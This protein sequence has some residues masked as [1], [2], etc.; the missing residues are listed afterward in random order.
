MTKYS[1][2]LRLEIATAVSD[3]V[4]TAAG[5]AAKYG[6]RKSNVERWVAL[7][8]A[9]GI[10][11]IARERRRY[12][13]E[14]KQAVV[15]DMRK[16]HLSLQKTSAKYNVGTSTVVSRWERIYLEEGVAALYEERRGRKAGSSKDRLLKLPK[17]VEKDLI[18]ENQRLRMEN[19]YL[20]KLNALVRELELS[21]K[22]K[23]L[24]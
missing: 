16:N 14:F 7:Y 19:D 22:R 15:E 8:K 13:G 18:A 20:K 24:R 10:A 11:G 3:G 23:R 4:L 9:H 1:T 12:T 2:D 5:A 21:E 17:T 6:M